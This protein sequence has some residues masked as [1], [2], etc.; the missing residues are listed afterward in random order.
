MARCK[1]GIDW[2]ALDGEPVF[3]IFLWLAPPADPNVHLEALALISR[4]SQDERIIRFLRDVRNVTD[5]RE[6]LDDADQILSE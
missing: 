3:V 2:E 6:L 5:M 4:L 1:T